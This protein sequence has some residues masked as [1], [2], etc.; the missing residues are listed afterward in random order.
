MIIIRFD[1]KI[2]IFWQNRPKQ[3]IYIFKQILESRNEGQQIYLILK[4][5]SLCIYLTYFLFFICLIKKVLPTT[6]SQVF[7]YLS[8]DG[9]ITWY[10]KEW[11]VCNCVSLHE[12]DNW[13]CFYFCCF[14][15]CIICLH[16]SHLSLI[17]RWCLHLN[18]WNYI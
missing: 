9:S 3:G 13:S 10:R 17:F 4:P 18:F 7:K 14:G 1:L 11:S 15:C 12:L 5:L 16:V 2:I 6:I 8:S